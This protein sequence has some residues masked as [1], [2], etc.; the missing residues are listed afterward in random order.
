MTARHLLS[1]LSMF[2]DTSLIVNFYFL[3]IEID[4]NFKS[5]CHENANMKPDSAVRCTWI[6]LQFACEEYNIT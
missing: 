3:N 4:V 1:G 5:F 6:S 2:R